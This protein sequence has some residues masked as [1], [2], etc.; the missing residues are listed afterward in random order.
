M[1][2]R[3]HGA[4]FALEALARIFAAETLMAT[5]RS[6]RV[7]RALQTSP[8]PPAPMGAQDFVRD[9]GDHRP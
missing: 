7:S 2:Q 9:P 3:R 5:S 8:M 4:G 1:I 6:R